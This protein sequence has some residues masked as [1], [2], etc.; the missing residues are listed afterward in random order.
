MNPATPEPPDTFVEG[1]I[2]G[3]VFRSLTSHTDDRGWLIELFR[4]DELPAE[5]CPVMAYVSATLPGVTRGPHAHREQTDL[6]AFVGPGQ[7]TLYLWDP[8][9]DS[10]TRGN[11]MEVVVGESNHQSVIVPPGVVHAYRNT[12]DVPSWIF[13][14]PNRLYAGPG[15]AGPVDEIR[16]EDQEDNPYRIDA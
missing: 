9:P 16:Y 1:P 11:R 14:C 15:K 12:G 10:P 2:E 8:R 4:A 3:V 6:F 7:F 13:N 5:P